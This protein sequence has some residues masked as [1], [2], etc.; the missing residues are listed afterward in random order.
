MYVDFLKNMHVFSK[1]FQQIYAYAILMI[2]SPKDYRSLKVSS[3]TEIEKVYSLARFQGQTVVNDAMPARHCIAVGCTADSRT[4]A[5]N[6][7][8]FQ[9]PK[10]ESELRKLLR[11]V[12]REG[13]NIDTKYDTQHYVI[14]SKQFID[15]KPTPE[16]PY[17][18]LFDYNN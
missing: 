10:V 12:G 15:C 1:A 4:S 8:F 17:P 7:G 16:N 13:L 11:L 5:S 6:V 2:S 9:L 14:C 3:D 18:T